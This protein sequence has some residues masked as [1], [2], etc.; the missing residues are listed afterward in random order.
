[1]RRRLIG[2][3]GS[4]G[5]VDWLIAGLGNPG[6]RYARTPHNVGFA[7]AEELARRRELPKPQPPYPGLYTEGRTGPGGPCVAMLLPQT[8]MNEAGR[9]VGPARGALHLDLD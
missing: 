5:P 8:Y 7:V 9:S 3:G 4:S 6:E 2:G 1:M